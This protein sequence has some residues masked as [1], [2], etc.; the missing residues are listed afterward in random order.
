VP[1]GALGGS[2][3]ARAGEAGAEAA[4]GRDSLAVGSVWDR[5]GFE[6]DEEDAEDLTDA[7]DRDGPR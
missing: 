3:G 5:N 1:T 2:V 7:A 4:G 6:N